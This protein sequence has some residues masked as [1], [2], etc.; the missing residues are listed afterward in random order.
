[1]RGKSVSI[2]E[3]RGITVDVGVLEQE[4]RQLNHRYLSIREKN[5]PTIALKAAMSVDGKIVGFHG[6]SQWITSAKSRHDSHRL[7]SIYDGILVQEYHRRCF[8]DGVNH[9]DFWQ[10]LSTGSRRENP[11]FSRQ[12]SWLLS[13]Q[14][15]ADF[16]LGLRDIDDSTVDILA[17]KH[18]HQL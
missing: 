9:V 4:C 2:L 11:Q 3:G 8:A 7:R 6:D 15:S 1:M 18:P 14:S 16:F 5:R 12:H 17:P 13:V 10:T